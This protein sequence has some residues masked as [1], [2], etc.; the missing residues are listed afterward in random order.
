MLK[1][2]QI[3]APGFDMHLHYYQTNVH[4]VNE[5]CML[6]THVDIVSD[7]TTDFGSSFARYNLT[8]R[9]TVFVFNYYNDMYD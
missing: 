1:I 9:H 6:K 5:I 2:I 7:F 8:F 3:S 4:I